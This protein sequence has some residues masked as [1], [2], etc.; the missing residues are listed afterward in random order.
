MQVCGPKSI[1]IARL[2]QTLYENNYNIN[3]EYHMS[4]N[5][6]VIYNNIGSF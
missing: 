3:G 2:S 5:I 4:I 1:N 6:A